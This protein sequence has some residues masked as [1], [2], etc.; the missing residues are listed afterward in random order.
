MRIF[1][2]V[3]YSVYTLVLRQSLEHESSNVMSDSL[4][5]SVSRQSMAAYLEGCRG[6][7]LVQREDACAF[8]EMLFFAVSPQ[9]LQLDSVPTPSH[10]LI[11]PDMAST[12]TALLTR[13]IS[14]PFALVGLVLSRVLGV[15]RLPASLRL[16]AAWT[17]SDG[18]GSSASIA[19]S[20]GVI[21]DPVSAAQWFLR[22]IKTCD[23]DPDGQGIDSSL[24]FTKGGYNAALRLA[25]EEC[26]VL[27]VVLTSKEH[28]DNAAFMRCVYP[29]LLVLPG[30]QLT[31]HYM[32]FKHN[33]DR[34]SAHQPSS[35]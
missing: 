3:I 15:R 33:P 14:L 9:S 13:I 28:D 25:K 29:C 10:R 27:C 11:T 19:D 35:D 30:S 2:Y 22:Y 5:S 31:L 23:P 4:R 26:Q 16:S 1:A 12:L 17:D 32:P 6:S 18:A 7:W 8:P 20:D 34:A 21:V 24:W